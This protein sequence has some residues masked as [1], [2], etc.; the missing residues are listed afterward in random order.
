VKNQITQNKDGVVL[1]GETQ[2]LLRYNTIEN[3]V[4]DGIVVTST[5]EPT[6]KQNTFTGNGQYDVHNA[7][8]KPLKLEEAQIADLK[9]KGKVN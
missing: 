3:N 2:P 6:L 5:A 7:T 4:R 8:S 1:S 9:V